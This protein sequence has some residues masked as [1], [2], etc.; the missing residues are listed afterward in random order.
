MKGSGKGGVFLVPGLAA[1]TLF[2]LGG[3]GLFLIVF[4]QGRALPGVLGL[5]RPW[6]QWAGGGIVLGLS[7]GAGAVLLLQQPFLRPVAR[8]YA[9]LLGPLLPGRWQQVLL[10]VAAGVGEELLFRGALQFWLG[11]PLTALVFVALHGYLDPRDRKLSLYGLYLVVCMIAYGTAVRAWGLL[12]A[13]VAHAL[14]DVL[15][16]DRLRRWHAAAQ[17]P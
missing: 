2:G 12:P 10:A 14:F 8:R 9:D 4:V 15:L 13:M 11:I 5:G 17:G 16:L 6:W 1:A 3:L 7:T